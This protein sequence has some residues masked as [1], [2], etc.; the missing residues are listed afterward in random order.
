MDI[1]WNVCVWGAFELPLPRNAQ[2]CK[3]KTAGK[4]DRGWLV[5]QK[6]IKYASRSVDFF[7]RAHAGPR[8]GERARV[9]CMKR[10]CRMSTRDFWAHDAPATGRRGRRAAVSKSS[11]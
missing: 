9:A 2:T 4:K 10:I 8:N 6:L 7:L 3:K 5:P 1:L 11:G